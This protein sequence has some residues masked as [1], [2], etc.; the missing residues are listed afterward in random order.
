MESDYQKLKDA[1]LDKDRSIQEL[2][3]YSTALEELH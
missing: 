2:R 1:C 3:D